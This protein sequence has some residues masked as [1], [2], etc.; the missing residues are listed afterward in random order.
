MQACYND[1]AYYC[2]NLKPLACPTTPAYITVMFG[3]SQI[4]VDG[5]CF[6]LE[7]MVFLPSLLIDATN[8]SKM[9]L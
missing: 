2:H 6:Y 9:R 3:L 1:L 5:V 8:P 4:R 7:N